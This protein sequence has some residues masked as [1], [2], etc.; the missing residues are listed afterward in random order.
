MEGFFPGIE[1][2]PPA[3]ATRWLFAKAL[4]LGPGLAV[5][6]PASPGSPLVRGRERAG[7]E[8][9][10]KT[11]QTSSV[12]IPVARASGRIIWR[13]AVLETGSREK[14]P[15]GAAVGCGAERSDSH[16]H[17]KPAT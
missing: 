11:R 10:E 17:Q 15:A 13:L 16:E 2:T 6:K 5:P 8:M 1:V 14:P 12:I 7:C 3:K 9:E 4:S